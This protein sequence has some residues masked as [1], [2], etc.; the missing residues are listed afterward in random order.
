MAIAIGA[1]PQ[2]L[3]R[4]RALQTD[5]S[6]LLIQD[7]KTRW[8]STYDMLL[9]AWTLRQTIAEWIRGEN[10]QRFETLHIK[11]QE[12]QQVLL[13]IRLL[14]P[15]KRWTE[16][17]SKTRGATIHKAWFVYNL[18]TAHIMR[19]QN[20]IVRKQFAWKNE[21][22]QA[23]DKGLAKLLAYRGKSTSPEALIYSVASVIDPATR[24]GQFQVSNDF[25]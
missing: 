19:L 1:S 13:L 10:D 21:L 3:E 9:R 11:K 12:W 22:R 17:V 25:K 20:S 23:L 14:G 7:V 18:I 2:R 15:F 8:N 4:F 5:K 6:L 16:A 24:L